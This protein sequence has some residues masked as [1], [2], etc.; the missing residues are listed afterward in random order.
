MVDVPYFAKKQ[1]TELCRA[2]KPYF[3]NG[4]N[5]IQKKS[6]LSQARSAVG[7]AGSGRR[8]ALIGRCFGPEGLAK[9]V[10]ANGSNVAA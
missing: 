10:G 9:A 1:N 3:G 7:E 5:L 2:R 4:R 6:L 8:D